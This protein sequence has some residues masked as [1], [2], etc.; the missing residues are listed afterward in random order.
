MYM[1]QSQNTYTPDNRL[2]ALAR[3]AQLHQRYRVLV[4]LVSNSIMGL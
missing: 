4:A 1:I 3:L 2:T